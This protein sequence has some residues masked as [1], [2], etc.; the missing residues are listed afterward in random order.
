M[1]QDLTVMLMNSDLIIMW[2]PPSSPNGV[3]SYEV[4]ITRT[5]LATGVVDAL[6]E[7]IRNDS[8]RLVELSLDEDPFVRYDVS[9]SASTIAGESEA[10]SANITTDQGGKSSNNIRTFH[11]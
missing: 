5:D 3:V 2:D 1:P 10:V 9:V 8:S 11:P 4:S 6:G 7:S